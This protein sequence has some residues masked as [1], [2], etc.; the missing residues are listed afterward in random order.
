M[1]RLFL[2]RSLPARSTRK[3]LPTFTFCPTTVRFCGAALGRFTMVS[4]T[5]AWLRLECAFS[6]VNANTLAAI[7][8]SNNLE[9]LHRVKSLSKLDACKPS[10]LSGPGTA[11]L[12]LRAGSED[13]PGLITLLQPGAKGSGC[14]CFGRPLGAGAGSP[15]CH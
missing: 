6:A 12:Q 2:R 5:M 14:T 11:T 9:S 3:S 4:M 1:D 10:E 7:P 15:R 8:P 13:E